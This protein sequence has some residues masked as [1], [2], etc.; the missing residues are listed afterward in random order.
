MSSPKAASIERKAEYFELTDQGLLSR[1]V[2]D[3]ADGEV[4]L[5]VAVPT[6]GASWMEVPGVG[7]RELK[8]RDHIM[9]EFLNGILGGHLGQGKTYM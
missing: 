7:A 4:Q 1:R 6:G 9:V 8:I 3:A 5:R 2:Y